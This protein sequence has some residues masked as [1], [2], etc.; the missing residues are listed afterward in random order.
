MIFWKGIEIIR[1]YG[2]SNVINYFEDSG[3]F[4]IELESKKLKGYI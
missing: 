4:Q 2:S 1:I 3:I